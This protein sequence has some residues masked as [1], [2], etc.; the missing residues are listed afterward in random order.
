ML[1]LLKF[2]KKDLRE[3]FLITDQYLLHVFQQSLW[4]ELFQLRFTDTYN[5]IHYCPVGLLSMVSL[6]EN[7]AYIYQFTRSS[8]RLDF[9]SAEQAWS[10]CCIY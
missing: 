8:K 6:G 3:V 1:L 9:S 10:L 4:S 2:S 5:V 7:L